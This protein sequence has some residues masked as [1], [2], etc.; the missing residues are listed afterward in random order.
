MFVSIRAR[1]LLDS[2]VLG[3]EVPRIISRFVDEQFFVHATSPDHPERLLVGQ[4]SERRADHV[5]ITGPRDEI[6][7]LLPNVQYTTLV[8][9]S[10]CWPGASRLMGDDDEQA[11]RTVKSF[12]RQL[13][14]AI[15]GYRASAVG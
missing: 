13:E 8:V 1:I 4:G 2:P 14:L 7:G 3:S 11:L 6:D 5:M 9:K 15:Q 12:A 10:H